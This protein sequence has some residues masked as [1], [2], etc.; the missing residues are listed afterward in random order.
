MSEAAFADHYG[1][2]PDPNDTNYEAWAQRRFGSSHFDPSVW[3][4]AEADGKY[5][6]LAWCVLGTI[7]E[8]HTA[9]IDN[10]GVA[11][12]FRQRG[13][14]L[15]LLYC[16]FR[17]FHERRMTQAGLTVDATSLTGAQRLYQRAGM[18]I[19]D[20]WKSYAKVIRDGIEPLET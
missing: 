19:F 8:P 14:G 20:C 1:H 13:L 15:A 2:I 7:D 17:D 12:D 3:F 16:V 11:R 10:L 5:A 9:W 18:Y 4:V 6:G